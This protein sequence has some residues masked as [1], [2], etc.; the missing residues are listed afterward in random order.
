MIS[1]LMEQIH[2]NYFIQDKKNNQLVIN[3]SYF[4][5]HSHFKQLINYLMSTVF[6]FHLEKLYKI[7]SC[8]G[9]VV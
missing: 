9:H 8:F 6:Y 7:I 4:L 3:L 1:Q 2:L 5:N